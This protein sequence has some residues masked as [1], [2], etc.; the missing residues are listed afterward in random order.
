[1]LR[2]A[3]ALA[4]AQAPR[5]AVTAAPALAAPPHRRLVTSLASAPQPAPP[6]PTDVSPQALLSYYAQSPTRTLTYPELTMYGP[7]PLDEPTL[8]H[9]AERT[10]KELLA[11]LARRVRPLF[12][13]L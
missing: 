12:L 9:S 3:V 7:P 6:P 10:R 5:R 13:P 1:M 4:R 8:L 11:G 2:R